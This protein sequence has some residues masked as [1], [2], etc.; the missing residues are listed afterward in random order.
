MTQ[1]PLHRHGS[2]GVIR[3][4][5]AQRGGIVTGWLLK[6]LLSLLILGV[7]AFEVG[8]VVIAKVNVD[9]VAQNAATDAASTYGTTKSI[10][11]ARAEAE[12]KCLEGGAKLIDLTV[13]Q[14]G[15]SL[16][17]TVEKTAKT[18]FIHRIGFLKRFVL[19]RTSHTAAVV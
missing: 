15:R 18:F 4:Q 11:S 12:K 14:D 19:A 2:E 10:D 17:V 1:L 3:A 6:L 8:A 13:A 16:T 7:V 9:S 5:H